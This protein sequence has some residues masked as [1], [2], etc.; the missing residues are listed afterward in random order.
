[1]EN[2]K[3]IKEAS[4]V[5]AESKYNKYKG[6]YSERRKKALEDKRNG[7][8]ASRRMYF[9][10]HII[11]SQSL[12]WEKVAEKCGVSQQSISWMMVS[13]DAKLTRVKDILK[14]LDISITLEYV[15]SKNAE[16]ESE[17]EQR[18]EIQGLLC[19]NNAAIDPIV[20]EALDENKNLYFLARFLADSHISV[21]DFSKKA[22]IPKQYLKRYF[23]KDDIR[24]STIYEIAEACDLK[25]RWKLG[26]PNSD[27]AAAQP[28]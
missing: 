25:I 18:F 5:P 11:K 12:T 26:E 20:N 7:N 27:S 16:P 3:R 13:D 2:E 22:G 6:Y 17:N 14:A 8:K 28:H 15:W 21:L 23:E 19:I 10:E 4:G 1:M 9:L 24:I